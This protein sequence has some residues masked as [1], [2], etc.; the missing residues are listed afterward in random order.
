MD[1][2]DRELAGREWDIQ[3]RPNLSGHGALKEEVSPSLNG[4]AGN[5]KLRRGATL[6][7]EVCPSAQTIDVSH[8]DENLQLQG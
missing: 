4:R 5:T 2:P 3:P 6:V 8:V 1:N 7:E